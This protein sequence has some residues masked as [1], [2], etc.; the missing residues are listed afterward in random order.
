[1]N[2][3]AAWPEDTRGFANR[4]GQVV[5]VGMDESCH[6]GVEGPV[7]EGQRSAVRTDEPY[8]W[9]PHPGDAELIDREI[10]ADGAPAALAESW[11]MHA[12]A[13]PDVQGAAGQLPEE[14][15]DVRR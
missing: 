8:V 1:M 10:H 13:A 9:S 7:G 12:A 5:E 6:D 15:K 14:L 2:E 4:A 3:A 11:K